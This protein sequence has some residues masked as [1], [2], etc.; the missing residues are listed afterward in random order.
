MADEPTTNPDAATRDARDADIAQLN[1][2]LDALTRTLMSI[3]TQPAPAA[4]P[5]PSDAAPTR[6][7]PHAAMGRPLLVYPPGEAEA[8]CAWVT[9]VSHHAGNDYY[10]VVAFRP[11]QSIP[12]ALQSLT[13]KDFA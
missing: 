6:N 13:E 7:E 2:K 8:L 9:R 11:G 1:A 4:A 12:V 3:T 5:A 10:D